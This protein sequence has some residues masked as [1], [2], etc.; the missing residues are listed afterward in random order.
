V[1]ADPHGLGNHIVDKVL[2]GLTV[3]GGE[4]AA[5]G[6]AHGS[7]VVAQGL[8]DSKS[9]F[10]AS[11]RQMSCPPGTRTTAAR[12]VA[13]NVV[14]LAAAVVAD[15]GG[16]VLK[17]TVASAVSIAQAAGPAGHRPRMMADDLAVL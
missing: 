4:V 10:G 15:L 13:G 8:V 5:C 1:V 9:R 12:S 14:P 16:A 6:G 7:C 3:H 11:V 17:T 2:V